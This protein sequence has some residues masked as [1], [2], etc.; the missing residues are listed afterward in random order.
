MYPNVLCIGAQKCGTSWIHDVISQH[1]DAFMSSPKELNFFDQGDLDTD[2]FSQYLD[3]FK[4]GEGKK[5]VGES[6]PTY[7]WTY[8]KNS[9]YTW[10]VKN[11]DIPNSISTFLGKDIR[12]IVSL[13]HPVDRAI[14][15]Y[16]H[17]FRQGR[18]RGDENIID[19]LNRY[20]IAELGFYK[21][22]LEKWF[23]VFDSKNFVL[24][25]FEDICQRPDWTVAKILD[26]LDL[27]HISL[28][29]SCEVSNPGFQ[30]KPVDN[31][32]TI[33]MEST[34]KLNHRLR[35][36]R[37]KKVRADFVVPKIYHNDIRKIF[38][39]YDEDIQYLM[40]NYPK[41]TADWNTVNIDKF[42]S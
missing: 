5:I 42:I 15:A 37:L 34:K 40:S 19:C 35:T 16:F 30:L 31:Y 41:Q 7:F 22:H 13:R 33:D 26:E 4:E 25:W 23:G 14:S 6:T 24:I 2:K 10:R 29:E 12:L 36:G 28:P 1:P 32:I 9:P 21:R 39:I 27:S 17:H 3:F 8:D 11:R 18:F 20:G 38:K